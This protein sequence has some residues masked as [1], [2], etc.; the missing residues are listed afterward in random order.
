MI[1]I[2]FKPTFNSNDCDLYAEYSVSLIQIRKSVIYA[3]RLPREET[4]A[5]K[6]KKIKLK[7]SGAKN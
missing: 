5:I 7:E 2:A 6:K 3:L 4:K 1:L